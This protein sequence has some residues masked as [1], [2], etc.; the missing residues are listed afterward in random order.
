M[1]LR[2]RAIE[3][4][5]VSPFRVAFALHKCIIEILHLFSSLV[6]NF[7]RDKKILLK[8]TNVASF[9]LAKWDWT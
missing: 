1:L 8:I 6:F 9:L 4:G 7:S 2:V 3:S 5:F